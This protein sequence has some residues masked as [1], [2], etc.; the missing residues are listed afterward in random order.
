MTQNPGSI[1]KATPTEKPKYGVGV[2]WLRLVL[3]LL[4]FGAGVV[5]LLSDTDR[6]VSLLLGLGQVAFGIYWT[7]QSVRALAEARRETESGS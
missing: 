2:L 4:I 7:R 6:G 3:G 5:R 1:E